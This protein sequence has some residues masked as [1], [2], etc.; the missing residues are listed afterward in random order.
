MIFS[1]EILAAGLGVVRSREG[2]CLVA[3]GLKGKSVSMNKYD[4]EP[5]CHRF[6]GLAT[7]KQS[8]GYYA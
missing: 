1:L 4:I 3:T 6:I 2:T 7:T 8:I 5:R